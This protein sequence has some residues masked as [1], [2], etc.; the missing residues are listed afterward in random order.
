MYWEQ[1]KILSTKLVY[2][3]HTHIYIDNTMYMNGRAR[4]GLVPVGLRC[5]VKVEINQCY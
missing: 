4:Y 3:K 2:K 5:N 1:V